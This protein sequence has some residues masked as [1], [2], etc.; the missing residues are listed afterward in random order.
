MSDERPAFAYG[1]AIGLQEAMELREEVEADK[2]PAFSYG[3]T[4]RLVWADEAVAESDR[5]AA[6]A[7]AEAAEKVME[8]EARPI[9]DY[10]EVIGPA[11]EA[12]Y[13]TKT[14]RRTP[15]KL[16]YMTTSVPLGEGRALWVKIDPNFTDGRPGNWRK[17]LVAALW[18][19]KNA[20][21]W[22]D[23]VT[24][25]WDRPVELKATVGPRMKVMVVK[26]D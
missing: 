3:Q 4:R 7:K 22:A 13:T 17:V 25:V 14:W 2:R 23:A 6:E 20:R 24:T 19:Y 12:V 10:T 21:A 5:R 1:K 11:S 18:D 16:G 15:E 9:V 26:A 8:V